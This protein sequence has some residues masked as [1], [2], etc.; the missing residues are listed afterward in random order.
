MRPL[1]STFRLR[2]K[3]KPSV[4]AQS[5]TGGSHALTHPPT[6]GSVGKI[7]DIVVTADALDV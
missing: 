5:A 6:H 1:G 4:K 3:Y 7:R 2:S